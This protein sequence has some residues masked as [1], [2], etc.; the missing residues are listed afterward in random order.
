MAIDRIEE[1]AV[2]E[3]VDSGKYRLIKGACVRTYM[4]TIKTFGFTLFL[5]L[6]GLAW[7]HVRRLPPRFPMSSTYC[8]GRTFTFEGQ[9]GETCNVDG[10]NKAKCE[11]SCSTHAQT[12]RTLSFVFFPSSFLS[13]RFFLPTRVKGLQFDIQLFLFLMHEIVQH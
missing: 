2:R 9:S 5:S 7:T 13:P 1:R 10:S 6:F 3:K 12:A 11:S 4:S 8:H